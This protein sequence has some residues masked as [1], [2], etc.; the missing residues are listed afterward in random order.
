MTAGDAVLGA[1]APDRRHCLHDSGMVVLTGVPEILRQVALANQYH[2]DAAHLFENPRKVV[3]R[4]DLLALND[5]EDLAVWREWP[6]VR[7]RVVL[8]LRDAPVSRR[9]NRIVATLSFRLVYR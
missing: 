7:F 1:D 2:A 9:M 3:D 4:L 5:D 8:L 6:D